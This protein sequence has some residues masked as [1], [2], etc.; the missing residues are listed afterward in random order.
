MSSIG[1]ANGFYWQTLWDAQANAEL[2]RVRKDPNILMPGDQVAIPKLRLKTVQ[3]AVDQRHRFRRRGV[4]EKLYLSFADPY[5]NPRADLPYK[6]DIEG[7]VTDG[8]TD[9]EGC[10]EVWI[11]PQAQSAKL[12]LLAPDTGK[13]LDG[14][15][16]EVGHLAP[17]DS[18]E[19]LA[20]RLA[21]L[22]LSDEDAELMDTLAAFQRQSGL[23]ETGCADGPTQ[24]RLRELTGE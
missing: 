13:V 22:G 8:H 6:L 7:V 10:I 15:T 16:F 20:A 17:F 21:N 14:Y 2:K 9:A 3:G 24:R 1:D 23:E 19:G 18:G 4:P 5:G 12:V 11:S